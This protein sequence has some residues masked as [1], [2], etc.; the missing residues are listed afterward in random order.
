MKN[1]V[2]FNFH[3]FYRNPIQNFEHFIRKYHKK[4]LDPDPFIYEYISQKTRKGEAGPILMNK[5]RME[6]KELRHSYKYTKIHL[7]FFTQHF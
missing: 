2:Q 5:P 6:Y 1:I 3:E 4:S 7:T